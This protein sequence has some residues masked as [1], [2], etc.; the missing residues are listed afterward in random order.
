MA[1]TR[2]NPVLT[3]LLVLLC[4]FPYELHCENAA[5]PSSG[6]A[7]P[8]GTPVTVRLNQTVSSAHA[9]PGDR[10]QFVVSQ[11]VK[12]DGFTAIPAG[13]TATG[14]I[15]AVKH[16]RL[17]GMGGSVVFKLDSVKL[18]NGQVAPL[19]AR[20][21]VKGRGHTKI[22]A[23]AMLATGLIFWPATPV[24]LLAHGDDCTALK[25]TELTGHLEHDV[26]VQRAQLSQEG[27]DS[28]LSEVMPFVPSRVL[29]REGREGDMVNL[30]FVGQPEDLIRALDRGGWTKVDDWTPVMAWHLLKHRL[31]DA[32]LPMA[33]FYVF[34]RVQDY[35]Y[36]LPDPDAVVSRRH[37]VRIWKTDYKV[38]GIPVWAGSAT[39]DVAIVLAKHGRLINHRI[40][41]NVDAERDFI[42]QNLATTH[43]VSRQK[44]VRGTDPVFQ[45]QTAGGEPYY[46]DSRILLVDVH[47]TVRSNA[48]IAEPVT[49]R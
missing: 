9:H 4:L 5:E 41:P 35:A 26:L 39:H 30:M 31:R 7:L 21:E 6:I 29:N 22:M 36:A 43:L 15:V 2:H 48:E 25:G 1:V 11:D 42:G 18:A 20:T 40:D 19:Q 14:T 24:F 47:Q 23:A 45:A 33:R 28:E 3:V 8:D 13:S 27:Q 12:A 32:K 44:Y 46:S 37:H 17:L 34:G 49:I 38:D 16:K 10:L